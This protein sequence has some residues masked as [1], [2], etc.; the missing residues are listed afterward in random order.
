MRL[1]KLML[2]VYYFVYFLFFGRIALARKL[3]VKI[4]QNCRVYITE[5]GTEPFLISIGDRVTITSGVRFLTHD[6]ST[7]LV[8]NECGNRYQKY[9]PISIGQDVFIGIGC[10]IMPGVS[11][12]NNVVIAAGSIVTKNVESG[13]VIGGIPAKFIMSFEHYEEKIKESCV[14]D[15]NIPDGLGYESRVNFI[16]TQQKL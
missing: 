1:S 4:G 15:E 13:S 7:W 11:I 3:G 2:K 6:G 12:G 14:N 8:R 5:W 9:N 10:I 16:L